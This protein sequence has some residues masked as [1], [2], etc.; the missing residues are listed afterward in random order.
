MK[1]SER[2]Y[3]GIV[4]G[5][6]AVACRVVV[7]ETDLQIYSRTPLAEQARETVLALRGQ[8]EGYIRRHP[9]FIETL[10]PWSLDDPA[11]PVVRAM[12]RAGRRVGVGPMAAVAGAIAQG[13]GEALLD[14]APE[15]IVENGGDIFL[16]TSSPV[17]IGL[18]AGA[19]PLSLKVGLRLPGAGGALAVCTSS[20]TL[21]HSRSFGRADAACM[22]SADAAL[23]DAAAT[24]V[25]NRVQRAADIAAAIDFA[26]SIEGITGAVVVCGDR[27]GAWG[28]VEL[29][30]VDLG[31]APERV[32]GD[33]GKRG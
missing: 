3:R 7:C 6:L 13:V 1:G 12:I 31:G 17:V 24:A 16:S 5:A 29:V 25:G 33:G 23:A 9:A 8:L 2:A 28:A 30:P 26:R 14:H 15:V 10:S 20:G 18:F 19:S 27:I 21:G 22:L 4:N 11:P 32:L